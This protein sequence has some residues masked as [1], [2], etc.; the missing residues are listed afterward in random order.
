M[1]DIS[2]P[3]DVGIDTETLAYI[4]VKAKAFDVLVAPDD[5]SDGSNASDDRMMDALEDEPDNPAARELHAAI[6]SLNTDAQSSL[7]A[8]A[9]LG[10]DDYDAEEWDEAM[11][12]ARDRGEMSASRYLMGMPMLGDYIEAGADKLGISLTE[13]EALGMVTPDIET[14]IDVSGPETERRN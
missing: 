11:E 8:L 13:D 3:K 10:R 7:I 12:A 14:S 4:A 5:L 2:E 6:A 9:W 1:R